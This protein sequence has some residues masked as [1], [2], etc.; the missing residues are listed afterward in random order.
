MDE[1]FSAV[2]PVVRE[3]LQTEFLRLQAD[4]AQDDRLRHP[5]TSR[6]PCASATG[7][8]VMS[9]AGRWS[10][11]RPAELLGAGQPLRRRLRG[12]RP[13]AQ[14]AGRDRHRSR[15]P[16]AAAGRARGGQP[17]RRAVRD[18]PGGRPLGRRPR[19]L[20][21]PA[22]LAVRRAR[23][24]GTVESA[25]AAW[26]RGYR[27]TRRS[28][29][30]SP[31]CCST[32]PVGGGPRRRPVPRRPHAR[33]AA[34]RAAPLRRRA[35]PEVGRPAPTGLVVNSARAGGLPPRTWATA[36]RLRGTP[37][38]SGVVRRTPV[39]WPGGSSGGRRITR[40]A[41]GGLEGE[42]RSHEPRGAG[43]PDDRGHRVS[44]RLRKPPDAGPT[45]AS[46][47]VHAPANPAP[48]QALAC[49]EHRQAGR[50]ASVRPGAPGRSATRA[51]DVPAGCAPRGAQR[52][53]PSPFGPRGTRRR[54][55][56]RA[57]R[58]ATSPMRAAPVEGADQQPRA[59]RP[60]ARTAR[61][62]RRTGLNGGCS[63]R[64]RPRTSSGGS[65]ATRSAAPA[66][67]REDGAGL[68]RQPGQHERPLVG[69]RVGQGERRVVGEHRRPVVLDDRD[70]VDVEGARAEADL[71]GASGGLLGL[72]RR[73]SQPAASRSPRT[74]A[75]AF[76]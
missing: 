70:D 65:A 25:G 64:F 5:T 1:P 38:G 27:S 14:A 59:A 42:R 50:P 3:R 74:T 9:P 16:G 73:A 66:M 39:S 21:A 2:D 60:S 32:R 8:A 57:A 51:A 18:G 17:R 63:Q 6:R 33:V 28:R 56:P 55:A 30:R 62:R 48:T 69:P 72:V 37:P 61:S 15:R 75:I 22:R 52:G 41:A 53:A 43:D 49:A 76:R 67:P 26:R 46:T 35:V 29:R 13:R 12:R 10:S 24:G 47:P 40:D 54:R 45:C 7:S 20:G 71:P 68:Q 31:R 19:R 44:P 11:S 23:P 4:R 36:Q 58:A 34:R